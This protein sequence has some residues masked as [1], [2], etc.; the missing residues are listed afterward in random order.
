MSKLNRKWGPSRRKRFG[1]RRAAKRR[2]S[3]PTPSVDSVNKVFEPIPQSPFA[4]LAQALD[5]FH[6]KLQ[7]RLHELASLWR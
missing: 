3:V 1:E 6:D 4:E 2:P 5:R 7:R